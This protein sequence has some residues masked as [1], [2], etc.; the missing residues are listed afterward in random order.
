MEAP[1]KANTPVDQMPPTI[2]VWEAATYGRQVILD[3]TTVLEDA[4]AGR[5]EQRRREKDAE[6]KAKTKDAKK[7]H[8]TA[9]DFYQPATGEVVSGQQYTED[10][11]KYT[12][13]EYA[14]LQSYQ[15]R[16]KAEVP[17]G[18]S[19]PH[20][21]QAT[22][23]RAQHVT[24]SRVVGKTVHDGESYV[25]HERFHQ[26]EGRRDATKPSHDRFFATNSNGAVCAV[27]PRFVAPMVDGTEHKDAHALAALYQATVGD[28]RN[29]GPRPLLNSKVHSFVQWDIA[30]KIETKQPPLSPRSQRRVLPDTGYGV[31][32]KHGKK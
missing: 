9:A 13:L 11:D 22:P 19:L 14:I 6:E 28:Q 16:A 32:P 23:G 20:L 12:H 31:P 8:K 25:I 7:H 1:D 5:Q 24:S 17:I 29:T 30:P 2:S 4:D 27:T 15:E 26:D 3:N 21:S 10:P 18:S